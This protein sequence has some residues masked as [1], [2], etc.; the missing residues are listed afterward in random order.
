MI[1]M[2]LAT[3]CL[4]VLATTAVAAD[5]DKDGFVPLFNGKDLSG[6]EYVNT[7]QKT[8][9]VKDGMIV[10][11]GTPTG[12]L[13]TD[14]HYEN[15]ILEMEWMHT[16]TKAVGNS[17]LFVWGDPIPAVG[18]P[19]TRGIEV[20]VLVNLEYRHK[21]TNAVTASSHGDLFSIWGAK[22]KPDRPH[23]A[24]WER[25]LPSENRAK[26]G[27]EWNH[28]RVEANNGV[29]KLHVNGKE[30]SGVSECNPRKGYLALESEGAECKFRNVRIKELTSTNPKPEAVAKLAEGHKLLFNGLDLEGWTAAADWNVRNGVLHATG[31]GELVSNAKFGAVELL[32]DWRLA[33]NKRGT[34]SVSIGGKTVELTAGPKDKGATRET[35]RVERA[36]DEKSAPVVIKPVA[37]LEIMNVFVKALK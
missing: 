10:T 23:P 15:F 35:I 25:C 14:R 19:Y 11:T 2:R 17:G 8:F 24:G 20:Q 7:P 9:Y 34:A 27:G 29:I 30:V 36:G 26:G 5:P 12:F 37:G 1:P 22:C 18:T 13:R 28:Y 31:T 16:N 6:W 33:P 21:E 4:V 3:V 32:F